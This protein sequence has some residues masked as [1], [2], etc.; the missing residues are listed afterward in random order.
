MPDWIEVLRLVHQPVNDF[1]VPSFLLKS[2]KYPVPNDEKTGVILV[3]AVT[4][5]T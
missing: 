4:V 1:L 3:Q 5:G 2:S